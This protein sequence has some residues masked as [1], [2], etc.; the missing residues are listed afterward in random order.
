METIYHYDGSFAG[1]LTTL[2]IIRESGQSPADITR[3]L[4]RQ[5]GLF[6]HV[7]HVQ[8]DGERSARLLE[9]ISGRISP[10]ALGNVYHAFL[11]ETS[12]VEMAI[13]RYLE[14]GWREGKHLD[15]RL[16]D[17][18]VLA[19]H[20]AAR[21]VRGEAYRMKG[22]VRFRQVPE[23][24]YYAPLEPECRVLPLI[25]PHFATRFAD[26]SWVIHD[27]ARGE[28]IIHDACRRQW[29]IVPLELA[30]R[31]QY[32]EGE[33]LFSTLWQRYFT[34]VAIAERLNPVLQRSR[35][36]LKH[37]KYLVEMEA[38]AEGE[39]SA[40]AP[41]AQISIPGFSP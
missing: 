1:L 36:P 31:P 25:A 30:C 9:K 32:S 34:G 16:A 14:L 10:R 12:D 6:C 22:F 15:G 33:K 7:P 41:P 26:Q 23:G 38:E 40:A 28:G 5:G 27:I 2:H 24:F 21:K 20:R 18:R 3:T 11:S 37:R 4:P 29:L 39:P 13:C 8:T 19:V 17:E 35:L